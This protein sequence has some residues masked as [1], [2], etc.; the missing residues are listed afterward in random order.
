ML[1]IKFFSTFCS[2]DACVKDF[3][4]CSDLQKDPA[5]NKTY[6]FTNEDNYTHAI[7]L[8]TAM[9]VLT[10]PKENVIGLACEPLIFLGLTKQ[11]IEYAQKSIGKYLIGEKRDLPHP[12]IEYFGYMWHTITPPSSP[13]RKPKLMSIMVS[14]KMFAPGHQYRHTLCREILKSKLPID[15][16]GNGCNRHY[17]QI[18]DSRLKGDFKQN[19]PYNDYQFHIAIENS[20]TPHYF[21]EK[22]MNPLLCNTVPVY[23]GCQNIDTYF[24]EMVLKLTGN[25]V[26][27][28]ALLTDICQ[29]KEKYLKTIK[30]A[31]VK[32]TI[33]FSN[34]IK[35]FAHWI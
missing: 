5:L 25:V 32:K 4:R 26:E 14:H 2:H 7:I 12:F 28:M 9:P 18:A 21:S 20:V 31:A 8:N 6:T 17:S 13:P 27:D 34:V 24:N 23:L 16:Y 30:L 10:I 19:E 3:T 11:F 1:R 29:Q 35:L 15:I 33:H 22:I